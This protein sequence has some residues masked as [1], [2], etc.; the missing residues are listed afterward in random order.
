MMMV[1]TGST[2]DSLRIIGR[3]F[4]VASGRERGERAGGGH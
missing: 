3:G 1:K 4:I 2:A